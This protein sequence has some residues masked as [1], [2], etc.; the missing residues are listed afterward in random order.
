MKHEEYTVWNKIIV[1]Q[2]NC[3]LVALKFSIS[4]SITILTLHS[5]HPFPI[6]HIWNFDI[7]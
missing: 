7:F 6:N 3:H 4:V 2:N 5:Y 1:E